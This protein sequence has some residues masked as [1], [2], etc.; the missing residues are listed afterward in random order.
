VTFGEGEAVVARYLRIGGPVVLAVQ[1]AADFK[2]GHVPFFELFTGGVFNPDYMI[3]GSASIRGV[4][5]GR[6]LGQIKAVGNVEL[7]A[8]YAHLHVAGQRIQLG[9]DLFFDTG[10]VWS[11]YTFH[12]PLDG[13]G[14]GLKWGAGLGAYLLWGQAAMF[15]VD[16]AYSPDAVSSNPG[17]PF[18]LYVEDG[19]SF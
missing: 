13:S 9:N 17:F 7:R 11:D 2:F 18:G 4:P 3:G 6:Y 14:A 15:R 5:F 8:L 16:F 10:R 19:L 12:S 1:G